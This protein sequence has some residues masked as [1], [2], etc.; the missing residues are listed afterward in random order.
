MRAAVLLLTFLLIAVSLI[1]L[2][3]AA[4]QTTRPVLISNPDSTRAIAF[5]SVTRQREPFSTT[6]QI[7]FGSDSATRIML[8]AMNLELQADEI[9]SAVTAEA[10]DASHTIYSLIVEHAARVSD[11]PWVTSLIVR[12]PENLPQAGDVL[13]QIKYRGIASNRVRIGIGHIG[14][15]PADDNNAL[16]T[17]GTIIPAPHITS[18]ATNL[19]QS[20]VQTILQQAASAA[21][22]LGK[23]VNIVV[24]DRE[25]NVLA[26]LA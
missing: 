13:V 8:F 25:G 10:E 23:S 17:P 2:D 15:G 3:G 4:A 16:P 9:A 1:K 11:Q 19:A 5:E 22:A 20:D 12:L 26:S 14:D 6:V 24:T 21:S 18:T 7:K